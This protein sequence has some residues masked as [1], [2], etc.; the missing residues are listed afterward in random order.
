MER[1]IH[2]QPALQIE[3]RDRFNEV[4]NRA[5]DQLNESELALQQYGDVEDLVGESIVDRY[6]ANRL[7]VRALTAV[8]IERNWLSRELV[9]N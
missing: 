3:E 9:E 1:G 6:N 5:Y 7:A 4:R 2:E 8:G